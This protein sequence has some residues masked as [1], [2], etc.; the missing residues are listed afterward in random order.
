MLSY[1]SPKLCDVGAVVVVYYFHALLFWGGASRV[2]S[3]SSTSVSFGSG[4]VC[5]VPVMAS[6]NFPLST[7]PRPSYPLVCIA[8]SISPLFL[9]SN[10]EDE[11]LPP[12][13]VGD[14]M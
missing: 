10:N 8:V 5:G 12:S 7:A 13:P 9:R 2:S 11:R 4:A 3:S 1:S 6:K 14:V